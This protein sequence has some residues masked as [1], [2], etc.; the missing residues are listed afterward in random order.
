MMLA[1]GLLVFLLVTDAD[2]AGRVFYDGSEAGN[3][4]LWPLLDPVTGGNRDKCT[5]VT[6]AEDGGSGPYAGSRMIRCRYSG[7]GDSPTAY[8]TLRLNMNALHTNELFI[9]TRFRRSATWDLSGVLNVS[10]K[11][12]KIMRFFQLG[13]YH[14]L[15]EVT[16]HSDAGTPATNNANAG[17]VNDTDVLP[18]YWSGDHPSDLTNQS[19]GWHEIEYYINQSTGTVKVWHDGVL[20]RNNAGNNFAG[21]KWQD[22]YLTSNGESVA[23]ACYTYYD[24]F[25]V[26]SDTGTGGTG[27]LSAG[28][29]TQGGG[30]GGG[31]TPKGGMDVRDHANQKPTLVNR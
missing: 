3:T 20:A 25:E 5:S 21:S 9:R 28:D 14:D 23:F 2:A 30:G 26:Y 11:S 6:V 29:I 24:E 7:F 18:T 31:S 8:E 4:D 15:F 22:F 16:G 1:V 13:P 27:T 19:T 12:Q 17:N 10:D